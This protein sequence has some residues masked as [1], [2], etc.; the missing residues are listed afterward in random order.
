LLATGA[1]ATLV[2]ESPGRPIGYEEVIAMPPNR[3]RTSI[4]MIAGAFASAVVLSAGLTHGQDFQFDAA[5]S[6]QVLENYLNR[7]IS[8]AEQLWRTN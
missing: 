4:R 8:F 2:G 6:R 7:S 3:K 1:T 5:I